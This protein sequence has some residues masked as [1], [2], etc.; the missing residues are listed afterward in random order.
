MREVDETIVVDEDEKEI[1]STLQDGE[2]IIIRR[3]KRYEKQ[4]RQKCAKCGVTICYH[5]N[6]RYLYIFKDALTTISKVY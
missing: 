3:D 2:S 5:Q 1:K 6:G 4:E